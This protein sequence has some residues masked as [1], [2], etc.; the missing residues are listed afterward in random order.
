MR[1]T[2]SSSKS[3]TSALLHS[4]PIIVAY[5]VSH[6]AVWFT[7]E[8]NLCVTL[9]VIVS[10]LA[11]EVAC[12]GS[13]NTTGIEDNLSTPTFH[14]TCAFVIIQFI[15]LFLG[16]CARLHCKHTPNIECA[17]KIETQ[18]SNRQFFC[19]NKITHPCIGRGRRRQLAI[20]R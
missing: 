2:T 3:R 14:R 10:A 12:C 5:I 11:G 8:L 7:Y 17:V 6:A 19:K 15:E 20:F 16:H 4:V 1:Q 18:S 13:F 9:G